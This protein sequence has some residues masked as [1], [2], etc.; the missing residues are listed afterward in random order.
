MRF[1]RDMRVKN[2]AAGAMLTL[3]KITLEPHL[4]INY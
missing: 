1:Y 2:R 4:Q 3:Q